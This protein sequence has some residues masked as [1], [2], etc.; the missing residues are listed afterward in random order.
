MPRLSYQRRNPSQ[1]LLYQ[2]VQ[3]HLETFTHHAQSSGRC[4]PGFVRAEFQAFSRCGILSHGFARFEC[5]KCRHN[6]LVA[7][8]CKR[9]GFC[10]SCGGR[11]MT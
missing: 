9:R 8:S 6:H 3:N 5:A 11:R 2:V 1:T 7:F 4:L 10:P